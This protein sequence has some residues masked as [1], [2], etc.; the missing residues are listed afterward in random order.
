MSTSNSLRA[1]LRVDSKPCYSDAMRP[2]TNNQQQE[3]HEHN[4]RAHRLRGGGAAKVRWARPTEGRQ[5]QFFMMYP[6][7]LPSDIRL[8]PLL[9]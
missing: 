3:T 7:L 6:G 8:L 1:F 9:R 4:G 5:G 2:P